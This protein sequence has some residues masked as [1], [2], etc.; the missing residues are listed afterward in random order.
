MKKLF[1]TLILPVFLVLPMNEA[2][3]SYDG[4]NLYEF[5]TAKEDDIIYG[6]MCLGY[7]FGI[8]D[9]VKIFLTKGIFMDVDGVKNQVGIIC[10]PGVTGQQLKD[11]VV[12]YLR[13]Y[14]EKRHLQARLIA[15]DAL[16]KAFPCK[17]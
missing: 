8:A 16:R 7:L 12:K 15:V 13:D 11:V 3:A 1:L 4:N 5:C 10:L 14:P 17:D 9:L 6:G 2:R